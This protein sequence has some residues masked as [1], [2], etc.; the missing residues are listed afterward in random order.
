[1]YVTVFNPSDSPV[2]LDEEGRSVGGG[3][4]AT[5]ETTDDVTKAALADGRLV[6]VDAPESDPDRRYFNAQA[7][8]T[9]EQTAR[10]GERSDTLSEKD[11]PQLV[12]IARSQGV[13]GDEDDLSV[14]EL[15][16]KLVRSDVE[17]KQTPAKKSAAAPAPQNPKE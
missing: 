6:K 15:R 8:G 14:T 4:W 12:K 5:A 16:R 9:F 11:K 1:M 10:Y 13:I 7:L 2:L 3:E 17:L